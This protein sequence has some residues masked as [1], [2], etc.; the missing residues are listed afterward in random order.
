MSI[1]EDKFIADDDI[2][3]GASTPSCLPLLEFIPFH[4]CLPRLKLFPLCKH[5]HKVPK[6]RRQD[7][8]QRAWSNASQQPAIMTTAS[9]FPFIQILRAVP[10]TFGYRLTNKKICRFSITLET[11]HVHYGLLSLIA[12][13]LLDVL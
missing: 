9:L 8:H 11:S 7:E 4:L 1:C 3:V 2:T 5:F 10:R 12:I 6:S 13:L